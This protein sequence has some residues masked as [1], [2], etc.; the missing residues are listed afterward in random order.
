MVA[1]MVGDLSRL[2]GPHFVRIKC[3]HMTQLS[4]TISSPKHMLSDPRELDT[5]TMNN[6]ISD[7]LNATRRTIG[8]KGPRSNI[9]EYVGMGF[10]F[11]AISQ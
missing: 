1:Y 9:L 4:V 6:A 3:A 5:I 10:G 8:K 11:R 7:E 2:C